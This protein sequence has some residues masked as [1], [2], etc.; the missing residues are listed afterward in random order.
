MSFKPGNVK[1]DKEVKYKI[2]RPFEMTKEF[3]EF[4]SNNKILDITYERNVCEQGGLTEVIAVVKYA[5]TN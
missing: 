4:I 5:I 1:R 3:E 2:L